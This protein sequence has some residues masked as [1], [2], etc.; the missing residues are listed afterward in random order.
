M[1]ASDIFNQADSVVY[2]SPI[3]NLSA[4]ELEQI[5]FISEMCENEKTVVS[6]LEHLHRDLINAYQ[7][8]NEKLS[9]LDRIYSE[10]DKMGKE[11]PLRS[12]IRKEIVS[13][14]ELFDFESYSHVIV[15][16]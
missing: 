3:R 14:N 4:P 9:I 15:R 5:L 16:K 2:S 10:I 8:R 13:G 6:A 11:N 7:T 12:Q 1:E